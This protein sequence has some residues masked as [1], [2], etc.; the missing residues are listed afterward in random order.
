MRTSVSRLNV[1]KETFANAVKKDQ[2]A[3]CN[4]RKPKHKKHLGMPS[5][6]EFLRDILTKKNTNPENPEKKWT[7]NQEGQNEK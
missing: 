6:M 2:W 1:L 5:F 7:K 3:G 4:Y